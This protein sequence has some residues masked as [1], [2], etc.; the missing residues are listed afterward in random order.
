[1]G[2]SPQTITVT[3]RRVPL[4]SLAQRE[5]LFVFLFV[6]LN[7]SYVLVKQILRFQQEV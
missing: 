6:C 2:T 1:M 3:D 4:G 5:L 7:T